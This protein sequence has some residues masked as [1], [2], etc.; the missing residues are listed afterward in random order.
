MKQ[1]IVLLWVIIFILLVV[2]KFLINN[3]SI[4]NLKHSDIIFIH[5]GKTGGSTFYIPFK[6]KQQHMIKAKYIPNKKYIISIR[7]P[8][9]RFVSAYNNLLLSIK[10]PYGIQFSQLEHPASQFINQRNKTNRKYTFNED[11]DEA[12]KYFTDVN[13]FAENIFS[14]DIK[15]K[16]YINIILNTK[17]VLRGI[18]WYLYNGEFIEKYHNDIIYVTKTKTLDNDIQNVS[19]LINFPIGDYKFRRNADGYMKISKYLS[20]LAIDN[21]KK[22]LKDTDYKTLEIMNKY[23]L[24]DDDYLQYCYEYENK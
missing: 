10:T 11:T 21:I 5:I 20:P 9:S 3:F 15:V 16:K 8:I 17:H 19:K 2:N 1:I 6:F 7:H 13:H 18:G 4:D 12:I 14:D 24:I 22:L 23:D